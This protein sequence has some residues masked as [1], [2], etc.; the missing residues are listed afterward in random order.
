LDEYEITQRDLSNLDIRTE[1]LSDGTRI[2]EVTIGGIDFWSRDLVLLQDF[3]E[4]IG[5]A[6]KYM[7]E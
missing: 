2:H 7:P 6:F 4:T 5:Q 3:F 1:E